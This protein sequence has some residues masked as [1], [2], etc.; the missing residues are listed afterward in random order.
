MTQQWHASCRTSRNRFATSSTPSTGFATLSCIQRK[1]ARSGRRRL[2]PWWRTWTPQR[3]LLPALSRRRRSFSLRARRA[4]QQRQRRGQGATA[5]PSTAKRHRVDCSSQCRIYRLSSPQ[6][7]STR[8]RAASAPRSTRRTLLAATARACLLACCRHAYQ[9]ASRRPA[10][11]SRPS[12]TSRSSSLS[13][14]A[15][16]SA[17]SQSPCAA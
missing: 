17:T 9:Q 7:T 15:H 10:P 4:R 3:H 11:R 5:K 6:R 1:C 16:V 13:R 8:E 14:R 12:R 2:T